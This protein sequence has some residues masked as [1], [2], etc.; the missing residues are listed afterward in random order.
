MTLKSIK[1]LSGFTITRATTSRSGVT[2][3]D[4]HCRSY[5]HK[6][7][8]NSDGIEVS[9]SQMALEENTTFSHPSIKSNLGLIAELF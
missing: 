5:Y 2:S 7:Y 6:E 3:Q 4:S 8:A 9:F 1:K